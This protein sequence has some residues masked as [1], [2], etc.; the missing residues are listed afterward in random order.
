[1]FAIKELGMCIVQ[2]CDHLYKL[3]GI[4]SPTLNSFQCSINAYL[5]R[6]KKNH[7]LK[8]FI[9][10]YDIVKSVEMAIFVK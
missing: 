9:L 3:I 4:V 10:F 8:T 6:I 7:F 1:M 2:Y 5:A